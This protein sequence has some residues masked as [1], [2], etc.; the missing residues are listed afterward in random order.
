MKLLIDTNLSPLWVE[1]FAA[2]GFDSVHWSIVG[3]ASA[4]DSEIMDFARANGL[5]VFTHDL[6]FGTLLT[7]QRQCQP[8]VIQLRTQDVLPTG[9]GGIV[10]RALRAC[11]PHLES[12]ALVTVDPGRQRI[13]LLPI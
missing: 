4:P 11:G 6:D 2:A 8:S 12:G 3:A 1:F 13:R 10:L 9:S 5:I 7:R